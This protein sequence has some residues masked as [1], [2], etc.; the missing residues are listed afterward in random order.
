MDAMSREVLRDILLENICITE[1]K[2]RKSLSGCL[3]VISTV[4]ES[5]ELK[6]HSWSFLPGGMLNATLAP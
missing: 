6:A 4:I 5:L 3:I 2:S 1:I